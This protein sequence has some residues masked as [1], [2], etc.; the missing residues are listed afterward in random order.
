M[1]FT[2]ILGIHISK[3]T[4]DLALWQNSAN[5]NIVNSKLSNNLKGYKALLT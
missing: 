5:P 2:H 1:Q 4:I 3:D